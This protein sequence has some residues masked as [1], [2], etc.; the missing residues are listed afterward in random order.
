MVIVRC[1]D[2]KEIVL[3]KAGLDIKTKSLVCKCGCNR[4]DVDM[5]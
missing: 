2:C 3:K 5:E 1:S 4:F